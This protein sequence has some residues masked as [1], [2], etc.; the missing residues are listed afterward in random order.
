A[1]NCD[2]ITSLTLPDSLETLGESAFAYCPVASVTFGSGLKTIGE[3]AFYKCSALT[4]VTFPDSLETIGDEAF[5]Y[6]PV[7]SVTFGSGLKSIGEGA[8]YRA[9]LTSVTLPDSLEVIGGF[10]F[11][12]CAS[13]SSVTFGSG[14]KTIG[15]QAFS[16]CASLTSVTLPDSLETVDIGV[17]IGC[18]SLASIT[19][20]SGLKTIGNSMFNNCTSLTSV[21]FPDEVEVIGDYA[22][23]ACPSLTSVT[24]GSG[25]KT[26]RQS[27]FDDCEALTSVTL[28]DSL[29]TIGDYAFQWCNA[30]ETVTIGTGLKTIGDCAFRHCNALDTVYYEGSKPMWNAID[31]SDYDNDPILNATLV[32]KF[33]FTD[34]TA[35]AIS[36]TERYG[37]TLTAT[38]TD[39]PAEITDAVIN[40]RNAAGDLLGTGATYVLT[41][42]EIG[43][44]VYAEL[45]SAGAAQTVKSDETGT[46]GKAR[47]TGY[48]LPTAAAI[49][50]P[51]T[52]AEATLTGGD[53]G[54]V[55]GV[56]TWD[57]PDEKPTSEQNGSLY[58]LTFTPTGEYA[59]LY[60]VINAKLA[61][62]VN[63]A[64][65]EPKTVEDP[66]TGLELEADFAQD[67]EVTL[68]DIPYSNNAYLALLRA[69]KND[70]T[71]LGKLVLLK[72]VAFT[73][74]GEPTDEAYTGTVT[75][76]SYVGEKLAGN[77]YSV[78]FFIDGAPVSYVGTVDA[79]GVLVI[80][81]VVL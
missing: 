13:L 16:W 35:I 17:F 80:E 25:L 6:C 60:E 46:I 73:I 56:W 3:G 22:F 36:G 65:F 53:V 55:E 31:I 34:S 62:T 51:Q 43:T 79:N 37:A 69:S 1:F 54:G 61:I 24:F 48:T 47:I 2:A 14:L 49:M 40:W 67:V 10:A 29:E 7:A 41:A 18:S 15:Q 39:L 11:Y 66:A 77:E 52:L 26:I 58:A 57:L 45:Y 50:Y 12:S 33:A 30:L 5:K 19:F 68:T 74:N 63:P 76:R 28:P 9:A 4:S 20:G 27:A 23:Y 75:I 71:G 42:A 44:T 38:V 78:W 59:A 70:A 64:P 21:T 72:T 8:F 81:N 32:C